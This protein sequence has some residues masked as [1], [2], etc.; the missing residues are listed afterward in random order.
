MNDIARFCAIIR[1]RSKENAQAF[2]LLSTK[3]LTG[4]LFS[5]LR[6]ELDSMIRVIYL[7]QISDLAERHS[8]IALTLDSKKWKITDKQM[9]GIANNLQGWTE[10][11]YKFGCGFIH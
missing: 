8:L 10:Y 1:Q 11:V 7:L 4:Q 3:N 9:V 2:S 5:I 6:Q